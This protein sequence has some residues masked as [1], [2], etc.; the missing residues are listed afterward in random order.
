MLRHH[1]HCRK[2][3]FSKKTGLIKIIS[4]SLVHTCIV[5]E[6]P[7]IRKTLLH[8]DGVLY[9]NCFY[10]NCVMHVPLVET[11]LPRVDFHDKVLVK[12][13]IV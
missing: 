8:L 2:V 6:E 12:T 4:T 3:Y 1:L 7:R 5:V 13:A 11:V 9:N 10:Y